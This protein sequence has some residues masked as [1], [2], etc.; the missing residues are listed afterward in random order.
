MIAKISYSEPLKVFRQD[1]NI[2][3]KAVADY[4]GVSTSFISAIE[5]GLARLPL[6]ML[7]KLIENPNSWDPTALTTAALGTPVHYDQRK[8]YGGQNR[9][10]LFGS[11]EGGLPSN[12][13][14]GIIEEYKN[15]IE[16]LK[17]QIT[18]LKEENEKLRSGAR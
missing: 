6:V 2:P 17:S 3:Q 1:N 5:R 15:I 12:V 10:N 8:V 14:S 7:Q 16:E 11:L 4:L 18:A 13:F 9:E